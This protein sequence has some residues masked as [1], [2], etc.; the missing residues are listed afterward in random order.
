MI[1]T[2]IGY[3]STTTYDNDLRYYICL[4]YF[5]T[6]NIIFTLRTIQLK[7]EN[8]EASLLN[9][10]ELAIFKQKILLDLL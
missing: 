4:Q 1:T 5:L 3:D 7:Y 8:V 6:R 2:I 10:L 9:V